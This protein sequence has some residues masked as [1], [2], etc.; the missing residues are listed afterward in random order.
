MNENG[1]QL[2][3]KHRD[4]ES[5]YERRRRASLDD[6]R[7]EAAAIA[8]AIKRI[9][10]SV[11]QESSAARQS[12]AAGKLFEIANEL[13][14]AETA[15]RR[16]LAADGESHEAA[17]RLVIVLAKQRRF[18]EALRLGNDLFVK[19][20]TAVFGSLVYE[21]PLSLCTV[22]GD[23]HR[24]SGDFAVAAS[25]FRE[26]AKLEDGAPY[27]VNQAIVS[28]TLAGDAQDAVQFAA[29]HPNTHTSERVASV[30][31]LAKELDPRHAI[32][33]QVASRANLGAMEAMWVNPMDLVT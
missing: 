32:V 1:E 27:A 19:A 31:R 2:S 22:L 29:K 4:F 10:E 14:S 28:M 12:L 30:L 3:N 9:S 23:I 6:A 18:D 7:L 5:V 8:G 26:A 16:S 17:A 15:Y 21:G 25:F 20:P 33:K 24:L 11:N 13:G